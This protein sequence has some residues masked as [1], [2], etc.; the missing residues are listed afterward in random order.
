DFVTSTRGLM[1]GVGGSHLKPAPLLKKWT[2]SD[3]VPHLIVMGHGMWT[4]VNREMFSKRILDPYDKILENWKQTA[5]VLVSL[6]LRTNVIVWPQNKK[7]NFASLDFIKKRKF[8]ME[9]ILKNNIYNDQSLEWIEKAMHQSLKNSGLTQWDSLV[10]FNLANIRECEAIREVLHNTT[11]DGANST[12][13]DSYTKSHRR[14]RRRTKGRLTN[15]Y[16]DYVLSVLKNISIKELE[17]LYYS[18]TLGCN[19][20]LHNSHMT[21]Q[22]EIYMIYNLLCNQFEEKQSDLCCQM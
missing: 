19:D 18:P 22:D 2:T 4:F 1:T 9:D 10:P 8:K 3:N 13:Y 5:D 15:Q 20:W 11:Y 17:F 14:K 6:G 21:V 12:I 7:R 16:T